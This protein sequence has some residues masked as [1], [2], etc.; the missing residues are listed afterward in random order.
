MV[1]SSIETYLPPLGATEGNSSGMQFESLLDNPDQQFRK[2][3]FT[4][5]VGV[6]VTWYLDLRESIVRP[7][8]NCSFKCYLY[9][10]Y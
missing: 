6:F 1:S 2:G 4:P 3:L 5:S 9:V 10:Y 7:D 8:A